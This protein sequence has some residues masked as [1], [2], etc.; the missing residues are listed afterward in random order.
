MTKAV[1]II[2]GVKAD[3]QQEAAPVQI[4]AQTQQHATWKPAPFQ[5]GKAVEKSHLEDIQNH[6]LHQ[7][8]GVRIP[9]TE[10]ANHLPEGRHG[11]IID[12]TSSYEIALE[13]FGGLAYDSF[14]QTIMVVSNLGL[15]AP[16]EYRGPHALTEADKV[17]LL[18]MT[19]SLFSLGSPLGLNSAIPRVAY[20][21]RYNAVTDRFE[22][23]YQQWDGHTGHIRKLLG[24]IG[25]DDSD[26]VRGDY[27][28][29]V[30]TSFMEGIL[31]RAYNPGAAYDHC[32][33]LA[34]TQGHGKTT[35][36]RTLA[37]GDQYY[38]DSLQSIDGKDA[39]V[40]LTGK[41]IVNFDE[42][43]AVTRKKE[44]ESIKNFLTRTSD[45]FRKPYDTD[46]HDYPRTNVFASTTNQS[47]FLKDPTG[48]RRFWIMEC[49]GEIKHRFTDPMTHKPT[50]E[51][52]EDF[53]QAWGEAMGI[54]MRA[55]GHPQI[56][57]DAP[58]AKYA[59]ELRT[60]YTESDPLISAV[61]DF[62]SVGGRKR[63]CPEEVYA[64]AIRYTQADRD[65]SSLT[66]PKRKIIKQVLAT[67]P[68]LRY[69]G[70]V[71]YHEGD[72][73]DHNFARTDVYEFVPIEE[74]EMPWD[75]R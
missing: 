26:T 38:T 5:I 14:S 43:C 32:L 24:Y 70:R 67:H 75:N 46:S 74:K 13:A 17:R 27:N 42:L 64:D 37:G 2:N 56:E 59:E 41:I 21:H 48:N 1:A 3:M 30:L 9:V 49:T 72:G 20:H 55:A 39:M 11:E 52:A 68:R 69:V 36:L 15:W 31:I 4:A 19:D 50:G 34:G 23:L 6:Y 16:D 47:E 29:S 54:Y 12:K 71:A 66:T 10:V 44:Q 25:A 62:V 53:A 22:R 35:F 7:F 33:C 73:T 61:R 51:S 65:G 57:L 60:Q 45:S 8:D 28:L 58:E 40:G 63:Y 18:E